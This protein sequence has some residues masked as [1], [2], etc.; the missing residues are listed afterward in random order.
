[1]SKVSFNELFFSKTMDYL[2]VYLLKQAG[3][4]KHTR[5]S[6]KNAIGQFYD[7]VTDVKGI[8]PLKFRFSDCSYQL[9]LNFSQY[10]QEEK[11]YKPGTVNQKLAAIKS[12]LKY[13]SDGDI[14]II[15]VYLA[16]KKVP[17]LSVPKIQRP[18]MEA[19]DLSAYLDAPSHTR[20]GNRDRM[21]LILLFDTAIRVSELVAITLG[22]ILLDNDAPVI[23]IHG[24]GRKE[25]S[26]QVSEKASKHLKAYVNAYHGEMPDCTQPLFYTVIHG[27][28]HHMSVRNVERIVKKYGEMIRESHPNIPAS[29]YPHLLRR[30]RATGLYRDGVPMEV[31]STLLGH[32]NTETTRSYYAS[33]SADQ[34]RE[35]MQKS[36]I[37]G[38]DE[39]PLWKGKE[40]E[41]KAMFRL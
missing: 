19:D 40:D 37:H 39:E 11:K 1:M 5:K 33:P 30:S 28:M 8:P 2:D 23:L 20:F 26:L 18:I 32:S 9:V 6:Y 16:V 17:E 3:R 14:S 21:I 31:V 27:E 7:Y 36:S 29:T 41:L 15:Q 25:R 12:Y 24:K 4:S 13:V 34:L 35:A 22:D 38:N 10:M